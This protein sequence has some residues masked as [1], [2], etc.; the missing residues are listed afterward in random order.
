M[1]HPSILDPE[2]TALV[3]VD[4]Q[5]AF[6]GVIQGA[7][8]LTASIRNVVRGFAALELPIIITE[9]YPKGLGRTVDEIL[10]ILP[11]GTPIVEKTAFSSCGA[12]GFSE[13]LEEYG[14]KQIVLCGIETHICV[15]QTAHDLIYRRYQ[16]HIL[17]DAVGSRFDVNKRAGLKKM[18][19]SGAIPSSVEM[20]LFELMR[21]SKHGKFREIQSIIK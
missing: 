11:E 7:E 20:A 18:T 3:V 4:F 15:N 9:Q 2:K 13:V 5:E 10:T 12:G 14:T 16:V 17:T 19:A 8:R 21:D 1:A 6:R